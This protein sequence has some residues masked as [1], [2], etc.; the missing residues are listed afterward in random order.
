MGCRP[1]VGVCGP[2]R[3]SGE[4]LDPPW[5]SAVDEA[6][7]QAKLAAWETTSFFNLPREERWTLIKDI[8]RRYKIVV[9]AADR[10]NAEAEARGRVDRLKAKAAAHVALFVNRAGNRD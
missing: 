7:V 9:V 3:P 2:G 6:V 5:P 1:G 8:Q 4:T 10:A